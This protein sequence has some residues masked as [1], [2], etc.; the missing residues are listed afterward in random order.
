MPTRISD[1]AEV[2]PRAEIG[3]DVHIGPFC[4][5]GPHVE[6][7]DGS[8]LQ[9]HVAI[10]GHTSAGRNNRFFPGAVIGSGPQDLSYC[11]SDTRLEIGDDNVFRE[12]VTVNR[13]AEKE[14][15]TTRIG[16]KNMFMANSH[17][18]HNCHIFEN[19][20]LVNGV[21]LGGHVHIHDGAIVSGNSVVHHFSTLG[22]LAFVS[23]GCRVPHDIPPYML[24]AGSDKPTIKT[25]NT[26]GMRRRGINADTIAVI[27][28][29]HRLIF[30]DHKNLEAVHDNF[31]QELSGLIPF[32]LTTLLSFIARQ[33]DGKLGRAREVHR[34]SGADSA[35]DGSETPL[36]KA[37]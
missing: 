36:R 34:K 17:V 11:D 25:I 7:G 18:A 14:D 19:V 4:R 6:I 15:R 31:R 37:A 3:T 23:G 29:A 24:T 13:G 12:G 1:L 27:K 22:T 28:R 21:L 33:Q 30:R 16:N 8:Q 32:E 26:V 5:V 2:D 10:M 20:I 35:A 9:S